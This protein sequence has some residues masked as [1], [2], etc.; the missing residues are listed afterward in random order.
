MAAPSPEG[1]VELSLGSPVAVAVGL[2][3]LALGAVGATAV[4][5]TFDTADRPTRVPLQLIPF[6]ILVGAGASL[7]RDWDLLAGVLVGGALVPLVG[8]VARLLEVRRRR[9][10]R[11]GLGGRDGR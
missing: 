3:L 7:V 11:D 10:R 1:M 5:R 4:A 2:V 9:W 8:T 6:G